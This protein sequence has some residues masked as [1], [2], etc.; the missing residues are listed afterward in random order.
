MY[1]ASVSFS[2]KPKEDQSIP[3]KPALPQEPSSDEDEPNNVPSAS[4]PTESIIKPA[5]MPSKLSLLD[6]VN[7]PPP[8]LL[9]LNGIEPPKLIEE[10][11]FRSDQKI[12]VTLDVSDST[13]RDA[14][15]ENN[16]SGDAKKEARRGIIYLFYLVVFDSFVFVTFQ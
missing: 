11:L 3:L 13:I 16:V 7:I 15:L 9:R 10:K 8:T 2:I 12:D 4:V 1:T 6:I 5:A 14:I